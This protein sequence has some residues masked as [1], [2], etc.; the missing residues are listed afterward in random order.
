MP[1]DKMPM[2]ASQAA[3]QYMARVN[4]PGHGLLYRWLSLILVM[5][6]IFFLVIVVFPEFQRIPSVGHGAQL[7]I[8]QNIEAGAFYYTDVAK[9][10]EAESMIRGAGVGPGG[11]N[12]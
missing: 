6:L 2:Q 3:S 10:P 7:I 11:R 5:G 9:V 1:M 12:E 8:E 4:S